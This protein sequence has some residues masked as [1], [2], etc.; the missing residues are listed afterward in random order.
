MW[1]WSSTSW[2]KQVTSLTSQLVPSCLITGKI[3]HKV[4]NTLNSSSSLLV[5]SE[6]VPSNG[7]FLLDDTPLYLM[8]VP[9]R[10]I[11]QRRIPKDILYTELTSGKRA[12]GHPLLR[13]KDVCKQDLKAFNIN[14]TTWEDAAQDHHTW[15]QLLRSWLQTY[16][17]T[18]PQHRETQRKLRKQ[19]VTTMLS[20]SPVPAYT[21]NIYGRVCLSHIGLLSHRRHCAKT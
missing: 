1:K 7:M 17:T 12:I 14:P 16:E 18:W 9:Q 10:L 11:N 21:C 19:Q 2:L 3:K 13:F 6:L 20:T 5:W 8:T 15:Q 4:R